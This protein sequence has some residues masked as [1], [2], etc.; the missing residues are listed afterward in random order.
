MEPYSATAATT[1]QL[2][3][4]YHGSGC[5]VIAD[6]WSGSGK[7]AVELLKHDLYCICQSKLPIETF[8]ICY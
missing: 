2:T 1:L 5:C 6:S 3:E 8:H 4:P 7:T